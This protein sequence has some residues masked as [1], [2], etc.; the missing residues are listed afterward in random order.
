MS[1]VKCADCG[2]PATAYRRNR[3]D[4]LIRYACSQHA[5]GECWHPLSVSRRATDAPAQAHISDDEETGGQGI[6]R[7]DK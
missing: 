7:N 6:G 1:H 4:T 3:G 2:A 5:K